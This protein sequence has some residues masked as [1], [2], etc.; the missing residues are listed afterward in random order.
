MQYFSLV[1]TA[2]RGASPSCSTAVPAATSAICRPSPPA[3]VVPVSSRTADTTHGRSRVLY[4]QS[5][6]T[7]FFGRWL[8]KSK[9]RVHAAELACIL[10]KYTVLYDV[11]RVF[12]C[13]LKKVNVN[14]EIDQVKPYK[15]Q[16]IQ[17]EF[18]PTSSCVSLTRSTTSSG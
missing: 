5:Y 3:Q 15:R 18:S 7:G 12:S 8:T 16:I 6:I 11:L 9:N 2:V 4:H 17:L 1:S 14:I 13:V 10:W